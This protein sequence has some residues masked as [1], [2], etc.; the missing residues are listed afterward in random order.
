MSDLLK[1]ILLLYPL[2]LWR[3]DDFLKKKLNLSAHYERSAV[4]KL[5]WNSLILDP[6][7][8]IWNFEFN[9]QDSS[10]NLNNTGVDASSL[11]IQLNEGKLVYHPS[12]R[13]KVLMCNKKQHCVTSTFTSDNEFVRCVT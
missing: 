2:I 11:S 6:N 1:R 8:P 5:Y 7:R 4:A 12:R 9:T 10:N 13:T 3:M